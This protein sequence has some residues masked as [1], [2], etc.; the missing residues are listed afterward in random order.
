MG[1]FYDFIV[2][3]GRSSRMD[4]RELA[5]RIEG[6]EG[7]DEYL[8]L[9]RAGGGAI[10][11]T[12]HMGSFE[13]GLAAL[14]AV[15]TNIHVVYKRDALDEFETI[16]QSLRRTLGIREAAIDDGW[17]TWVR[18]RDALEQDHVVVMQ[19]DRAMPGQK[20]GSVPVLGGHL[21]LPLGPVK[22]A[23]I[24]GSPIVPVF[25]VRT[26]SGQCRVF[27]EPAIV[28]DVTAEPVDGVH[29]ALRQIGRA[30]ER[31]IAAYPEQWLVLA[32][33]FEEDA[34]EK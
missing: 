3:V 31:F 19:A 18:L 4:A 5:E 16:R 1:H 27:A 20:A 22:L 6:V 25:A 13:V 14:A 21:S 26:S 15:E 17:E 8:A 29:P 23:Q 10:I 24:S 12:A 11:V 2:D 33:A 32:A 34:T 9:R 28:A 7:R 30:I